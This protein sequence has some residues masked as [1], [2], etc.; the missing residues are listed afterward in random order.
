M[1][2][3]KVFEPFVEKVP[4]AVMLRGTLEN[5]L[6]PERLNKVFED[7]AVQQ[8][9]RTLTFDWVVTLMFEVVLRSRSSL[10]AAYQAFAKELGVTHKCVYD[11][12]DAV[13]PA[14]SAALVR[15]TA[16][17]MAEVIRGMGGQRPDPLPAFRLKILDGNHLSATEHRIKSLRS[18]PGAALPGRVVAV[19]DP[20]LMLAIDAFPIEDGHASERTVL[21]QVLETVEPFDLWLGDR[22]FCTH[23]FAMGIAARQ[24]FFLIRQHAQNMP[25]ELV[26]ERKHVGTTATGEVFEQTALV[27]SAAGDI[28]TLRRITVELSKPTRNGDQALHLVTNVPSESA[29]AVQLADLY[30][31]RWTI[32]NAFYEL[33][34]ELACEVDSLGY[35][36]AALLGFCV[37]LVCYNAFSVVQAA[38]RAEHG[39]EKIANELSSYHLTQQVAGAWQGMLIAIPEE[40]WQE[41]FQ[42]LTTLELGIVLRDLARQV[43]LARLR[44]S[45]R[46]PKKPKPKI[47]KTSAHFSTAKVIP[48]YLTRKK[49]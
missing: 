16:L 32:E 7:T 26:G 8:Y 31:Q 39:A 21:P 43:D 3:P 37:A 34:V 18:K 30:R 17:D 46:G 6:S 19:L 14:V 25:L 36:P 40:E 38:L 13:E 20:A 35:P 5:L 44:K 29:D 23:P 1:Q 12:V 11:K 2:L 33:T 4:A 24:G 47:P 45:R 27:R 28:V 22:N 15:R 9:T 10:H 42:H 48:G 41:S 49:C